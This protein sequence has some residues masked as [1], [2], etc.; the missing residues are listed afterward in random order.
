MIKC[1]ICLG[2]GSVHKGFYDSTNFTH[3][4]TNTVT[5]T[6]RSCGGRGIVSE[7][8]QINS[9]ENHVEIEKDLLL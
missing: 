9:L 2:K 8:W 4:T 5:E 6:C 7:K 1:P 3:T